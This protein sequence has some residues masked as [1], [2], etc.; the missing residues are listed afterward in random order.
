M[1][2]KLLSII[3]I[4]GVLFGSFSTGPAINGVQAAGRT[5]YV[6][7]ITTGANDGSSWGN[8]YQ[9]L[10][11]ALDDLICTEIHVAAGTYYPTADDNFYESFTLRNNLKVLGGYNGDP[12]TTPD[13]RDPKV[14]VTTLDGHLAGGFANSLHVVTGDGLDSS[15]LLD[16]FSIVN[17]TANQQNPFDRGP[18]IYLLNSNPI[19]S[20]L[21]ISGNSFSGGGGAVYLFDSDPELS[22]VTIQENIGLSGGSKGG[23]LWSDGNSSPVLT[24]VTFFGN[25]ADAGGGMYSGGGSPELNGVTFQSNTA[26]GDGGGIYINSGTLTISDSLFDDS[27]G[28]D[29]GGIY[30]NDGGNLVMKN[31]DVENGFASNGGGIYAAAGSNATITGGSLSFNISGFGGGGL[32]LDAGALT[33]DSVIFD[34]NTAGSLPNYRAGGG[35]YIMDASP[36]LIDVTFRYN[37]G[38]EGGGLYSLR[39]TTRL[40]R[41]T[42]ENNN[43]TYG[44]GMIAYD[45]SS[46]LLD[47]HFTNN[48]ARYGGG[49]YTYNSATTIRDCEVTGNTATIDAAGEGGGL[50]IEGPLTMSDCRL[51]GNS[52]VISGGGLYLND[53]GP[54]NLFNLSVTNNSVSEEIGSQE[55]YNVGGGIFCGHNCNI[56]NLLLAGNHA[57]RG[58]GIASFDNIVNIVNAT[59]V[60]NYASEM[61]SAIYNLGGQRTTYNSIVWGNTEGIAGPDIANESIVSSSIQNSLLE[62]G[63][64]PSWSTCSNL[65][66]DDPQF[67]DQASGNYR[68]LPLSP[69]VDAGNTSALPADSFDLDNDD[70]REESIP[71]DL[72]GQHRVVL[73]RVDLGAYEA[74]VWNNNWTQAL[75]LPLTYDGPDQVSGSIDRYLDLPGQSRWYKFAIQPSSKVIVT[76]TGLPANYDLALYKDIS[77]VSASLDTSQDLLKL[78]AEFAPDTFS[79]DTF[80]PDTF[81]PDT[82][83]PDTFSPDTFSPDTFSPDT[84]SPDTFSPD[85]FSPDTFSP[86]TF[87]PDT[88]SP[89]TFSPDTFSPDTFSPD[90]F[91]PD[92]FSPDT[93][94]S[95]QT[96]SLIA[97]S[98]HDGIQGEGI[99]VNT[100]TKSEDFYIRVRGRNGAYNYD[101]PFHLS[102]TMLSGSCGDVNPVLPDSDTSLTA[103]G[104]RTLILT[105][106]NKVEGTQLEK[107]LLRSNLET[108]AAGSNGQV[109]D[110]GG[111]DRVLA[112][113]DQAQTY[114][115]CVYAM[116][117][118]AEAIKGIVDNF[119]ELNPDLEYL[120]LVGN[121]HAFPFFRYSDSALL[122]SEID[123]SPPVLDDSTSQASLKAGYILSQD[124]YGSKGEISYK[125]GSF[126]IPDLAVGRLVE[127][128]SDI[129]HYLN[130]Y[131]SLPENPG[132]IGGSISPSNA[133]VTGYDFLADDADAVKNELRKSMDPA[134]VV[135]SNVDTLIMG[136]GLPLDDP[137]AWTAQDLRDALS[138][139]RHDIVFLAGHFSAASTLAADYKTHMLASEL[140]DPAFNLSN[141]L[142]YSAG[143]HSGYNIVN[144]DGVPN[145]TEEPDWAQAF[146]AK[147]ATFIGGTGYQYGDTDFIE[148]SE[149]L[150]LEFTKQLRYGS[151]PVAVGQ[152]LV[153]A[154]LAYL[155]DTPVMR[156]IHEKSLLEATLFGLPMLQVNLTLGRGETRDV[157]TSDVVLTPVPGKLGLPSEDGGL[158]LQYYDLHVD[159]PTTLRSWKLN[160]INPDGSNSK[161]DAYYL[162][163]KSGIVV[164]PAEP[165]LPLD[166]INITSPDAGYVLRGVAW[167]GGTFTD[168]TN[169][170]PLT[171]AATEDLRA[172][173][174]PFYSDVFYPIR[175]WNVNY[176]D[177]LGSSGGATRLALMPAQYRSSNPGSTTGI[178]RAFSH[179]NFR[180]FYSNNI[181]S[182]TNLEPGNNGW[183]N[184]P[185]LAAPPDISHIAS[186]I[187][188]GTMALTGNNVNFEIQVTGDPSAGIQAVWIVYSL[189]CGNSS[190]TWQ[191]LDLQ[192]DSLDSRLWKG[193]LDLGSA[194][195]DDLCFVVQAVNGVGLGTLMTNQGAGYL[196]GQDPGALPQ[197]QSP[198][199]LEFDSPASDAPYGSQQSFTVIAK[200]KD[201][202]TVDGLT[203]TFNLGGM[204]R[205]AVTG[206]GGKAGANFYLAMDPGNYT[207]EASFAG[208]DSYAPATTS[209][210]FTL[211]PGS[212]SVVLT[213]K[214][215]NVLSGSVAQFSAT[216]MSSGVPLRSKPVALTLALGDV[217][218]YTSVAFTDYS[219][220][221]SWQVPG[222]NTGTY[223]IKAWF[224]QPVSTDLN[225]S[226]AYYTGASDTGSLVVEPK[227]GLVIQYSG[228]TYLAAGTTLGKLG[229]QLSGPSLCLNNQTVTFK[230][231]KNGDGTY[232]TT[233]GTQ[234]TDASGLASYPISGLAAETIIYEIEVSVPDGNC[235]GAVN[236]GTLIVAGSGDSSN[237]GGYYTVSGAG[238]I[239]FG[240]TLQVK[241]TKTGTTVTGQILWHVQGK[242]RIKGTITAYTKTCPSG[243]SAPSGTTCGYLTGTGNL[244]SWN[245]ITNNWTLTATNVGFQVTV[246]DGGSTRS[247]IKKVCSTVLKP[248]FLR[249]NMPSVVVA[250]E[251][252]DFIQLKGGNIF[253]K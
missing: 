93:F 224:A 203:I 173:H 213:P 195:T 217:V 101:Q 183:T 186:F 134:G 162:E 229:A 199:T 64:C 43:G 151:G 157:G 226:S 37:Q 158:G 29:G 33:L 175:P 216:V 34:H 90:T 21:V 194:S 118:Q 132:L 187:P 70:I 6:N 205:L 30:L 59:I 181:D 55:Y 154:K 135:Q 139:R 244:Y 58:G 202:N 76:L 225:L 69:A 108:L 221:A 105:D 112:A 166:L 20:N 246:A 119:R 236:T 71:Y 141:T 172:P 146:A 222:Q 67:I 111:D 57:K 237:G 249:M 104:S 22:D 46:E 228:D 115:A 167:R 171:G 130:A 4:F 25:V 18:G 63:S 179:M 68:L 78:G 122:A 49:L 15:A 113:S 95:A 88:F 220:R 184:T 201:G 164:N 126:P 19:L 200:N 239:N 176:Y 160:Q 238:R 103:G 61:G 42:F 23:G 121:D 240:Y 206:N 163:G 87:S 193:S 219:G 41:V 72:N 16:G 133:L 185:A 56:T 165:V 241:S 107:D 144:A 120:V 50:Y 40:E 8:A 210:P 13:D 243:T 114:P 230:Q 233:L 109:V 53:S 215:Q 82:F 143:C 5:C 174:M 36:S 44:G 131:L 98:A 231:D 252:T 128:A 7:D 242:T 227:T 31:T 212:S 47:V 2:H 251:S 11:T 142:V 192:Q 209:S 153:Q 156:G 66:Y 73:G 32:Y 161:V 197:G 196:F 145:V 24:R 182:Y 159:T 99:M 208:N 1:K 117:L 97:V 96:R 12:L 84:F 92:T 188:T 48:H 62:D 232:E 81:S 140:L 178:L 170:L 247:C 106:M 189:D 180:L 248:D 80:S 168:R 85:T 52:A 94:S 14:Y 3:V 79:P 234:I 10:Q 51:D 77:E 89:D 147:G 124:S 218:K 245:S 191:S 253:V 211:G 35:I 102:V 250:G 137:S 155:A 169:I 86:D 129:N 207:L 65:F 75:E 83:S 198:L 54:N 148:Y 91:S 127:T 190:G 150:Y 110:V 177:A 138:A 74:Q 26:G 100:W 149:R 45:G 38:Y 123:Y 39:S 60:G 136:G 9:D 214:T 125:S 28:A 152:A 235:N 204:G 223:S 27:E 116:N 17:G